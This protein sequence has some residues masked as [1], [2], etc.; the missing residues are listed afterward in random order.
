MAEITFHRGEK[1][2]VTNM[3]LVDGQFIVGTNEDTGKIVSIYV[4]T[5]NKNNQLVHVA[6]DFSGYL[7][8]TERITTL[9]DEIALLKQQ[10]ESTVALS[11]F[12]TSDGDYITT[13]TG[14]KIILNEN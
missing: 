9:E 6:I 14:E 3:P 1:D 7:D 12:N 13:N 4:D 8:N 10:I 2:K 5:K 11:Y